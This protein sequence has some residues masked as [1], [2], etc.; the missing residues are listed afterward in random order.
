MSA[1]ASSS[2]VCMTGIAREGAMA[3]AMAGAKANE[4]EV[5]D[6]M[7]LAKQLSLYRRGI[8]KEPVTRHRFANNGTYKHGTA[9]PPSICAG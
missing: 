5:S 8:S 2:L 4:D 7:D 3:G 9:N 1:V 6:S